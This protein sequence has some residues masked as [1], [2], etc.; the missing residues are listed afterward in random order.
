M[1]WAYEKK[2]VCAYL[3]TGIDTFALD[4]WSALLTQK[5]DQIYL[6]WA[7][8]LVYISQLIYV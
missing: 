6:R 8:A 4:Y 7:V 5:I 2:Q 1:F 3:R